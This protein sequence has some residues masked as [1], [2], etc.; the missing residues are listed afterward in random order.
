MADADETE[1][2]AFMRLCATG[3]PVRRIWT[4]E[5]RPQPG[6]PVMVCPHCPPVTGP[7]HPETATRPAVLAHLA[8]HARRDALPVHLRTCQC[9]E[10]GCLWHPRHRGCSGPIAL[11]LTRESGGRLWRLADACTACA[12]ATAHSA[13]VPESTCVTPAELS[14]PPGRSRRKRQVRGPQVEVRVRE[15]LSY[16]AVAL[17]TEVGAAARLLALQCALRATAS[18][19]LRMPAGLLRG[20]RMDQRS[21]PWQELEQSGWLTRVSRSSSWA[22]RCGVAAQLLDAGVLP[23]APGRRDRAQAADRAL[24]L[25]S[26][27]ALRSLSASEQLTGLALATYLSP[28]SLNGVIEADRLERVCAAAP[29]ALTAALDCLVAARVADWWSYDQGSDDITWSLGPA[30]ATR[31]KSMIAGHGSPTG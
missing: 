28:G 18:G 29:G 10:H 26:C 24:R 11:V 8:D 30:L 6:G 5:L 23:Q 22:R 21:S 17:P 4:V 13:I 1:R 27:P 2:R 3:R 31:Y 16:L 7:L 14:P 9:Q 20:M 12:R 15:M 25:T 19:R